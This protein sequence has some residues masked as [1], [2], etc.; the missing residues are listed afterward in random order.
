MFHAAVQI[1]GCLRGRVKSSKDRIR[2]EKTAN[3]LPVFVETELV[4]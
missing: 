4:Q 3:K 1:T 2:E